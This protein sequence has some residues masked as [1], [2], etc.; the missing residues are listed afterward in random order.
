VR[1]ARAQTR[2][3]WQRLIQ[4]QGASLPAET[5]AVIEEALAAFEGTF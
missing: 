5:R 1:A 4:T 2:R 3:A